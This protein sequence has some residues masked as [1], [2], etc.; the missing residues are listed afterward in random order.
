MTSGGPRE[1]GS[2]KGS[3]LILRVAYYLFLTAG[4]VGLAYT[5]Y[6]IADAYTYQKVEQST[7]ENASKNNNA[8][9]NE[10][11]HAVREGG[12]IG[13]LEVPR[14]GL[15]VVIVQGDTATILRRAVGHLTDTA[16]PG[17]PGNVILAGHRDRFF[18]PL[19][20]IQAGDVIQ[21]K[22]LDGDFQYQVESTAVVPPSDLSVLHSSSVGALTLITCFPFYYVGPAPNRFVVRAR[23]VTSVD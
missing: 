8:R 10:P 11:T 6:V 14:L 7:F 4:I 16:L 18:R 5:G 13:E 21:V 3:R 12:V 20:Y 2:R 15:K 23:Q 9:R 19:R 1:K 17:E 22:T